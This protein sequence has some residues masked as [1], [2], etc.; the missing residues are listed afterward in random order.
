MP[1]G[2]AGAIP[3]GA[4]PDGA[5]PAYAIP[6][7]AIPDGAI[8]AYAIPDGAIPHGRHLRWRARRSYG[9]QPIA[10]LVFRLYA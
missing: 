6:D 9:G 7:G 2:L 5:I 3:A 4:I 1:H 8:P 10:N